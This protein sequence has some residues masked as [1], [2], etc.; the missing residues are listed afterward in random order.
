MNVFD[1]AIL[2]VLAGFL[3]KGVLRGLLRE[4]CSLLGLVSGTLLALHF[5]GPLAETMAATFRLPK[6]F[7][8][9]VTF[10]LVF[11]AAVLFFWG[12][13]YLLARVVKLPL[14]GGMN[15]VAGG[16]F[17]LAEAVLVLGVILYALG[18]G[19]LPASMQPAFKR[20]QLAPPFQTLGGEVFRGG[21][22]LLEA[23]K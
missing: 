12:I 6:A 21:H 20:S 4:L 15:R 13:G 3:L 7:C 19:G 11:L 17:G 1:I 8:A 9:A 16:F 14:L 23:W 2:A 10:A 18:S 22:K 5:N